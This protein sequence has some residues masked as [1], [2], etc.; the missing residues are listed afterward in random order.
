MKNI[1]KKLFL[2]ITNFLYQSKVGM[3]FLQKI[4]YQSM[5]LYETIY[6]KDI[7]LLF[8]V[9]NKLNKFRVKTF[10]TKEPETLTWVDAIDEGSVLWDIGANIGLYSCY[11]AKS[12]GCR[13]YAFEP[14]VFNLEL[15]TRNIHLNK[16]TGLVTIVP[17]P[18][19]NR[20]GV[21]NLNMTNTEWG[22]AL[23]T[24]TEAYGFDGHPLDC[25]FSYSMLGISMDEANSLLGIPMPDYIKMDV[26]GIEHL[27]L[28][29]GEGVLKQ[30]KGIIVEINDDFI[31]QSNSAEMYLSKAGLSL[32]EKKRWDR[33]AHTAFENTYNQIWQRN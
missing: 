28:S 25:K 24:F 11:A 21:S 14:S 17:L 19:S 6:H 9:P 18:L 20:L 5:N 12:R 2:K 30:I 22:G 33:A 10:S 15:L 29:G 7:E 23:S 3:Y 27:I 26:D 8:T 13:V 32:I 31:L 4:S 16:A 1:I